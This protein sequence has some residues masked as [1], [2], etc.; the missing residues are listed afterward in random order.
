VRVLKH[1]LVRSWAQ[2]SSPLLSLLLHSSTSP[3]R[4]PHTQDV[5]TH[6]SPPATAASPDN[7]SIVLIYTEFRVPWISGLLRSSVCQATPPRHLAPREFPSKAHHERRSPSPRQRASCSPATTAAATAT[8]RYSHSAKCTYSRLRKCRR[9]PACV[10][11]AELRRA[12]P[13]R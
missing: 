5:T 9:R 11:V 1:F 13:I 8:T 4:L 7:N 12:L 6:L 3:Q 2:P 10:P